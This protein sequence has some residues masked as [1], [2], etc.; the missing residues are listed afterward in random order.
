V[1]YFS[2][3]KIITIYVIVFFL[4]GFS[5]LNFFNDKNNFLLSKNINLGLDLQ[6]GSY[7]LLEVD[8]EPVVK[9]YL[10]NKL[11]S[12][13]KVLKEKKIRYENLKISDNTIKFIIKNKEDLTIFESFFIDKKNSINLY[14]DKYKS[15]ELDY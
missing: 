15:F 13:R 12:L 14:Y 3:F 10:Q 6:G 5:S 7:L 9:Q 1:L 8:S 2:K 4:I 11:L